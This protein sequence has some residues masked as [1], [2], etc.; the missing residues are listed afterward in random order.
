MKNKLL[1]HAD[2]LSIFPETDDLEEYLASYYK[3]MGFVVSDLEVKQDP[4][5]KSKFVMFT[6]EYIEFNSVIN[7]EKFKKGK[8]PFKGLAPVEDEHRPYSIGYVT[9]DIQEMY[10]HWRVR[11]YQVEDVI[12][13]LHGD[14]EPNP[15]EPVDPTWGY[16]PFPS[17]FAQGV[18]SYVIQYLQRPKEDRFKFVIGENGIY[19]LSGFTFVTDYPHSRGEDWSNFFYSRNNHTPYLNECIMDLA[20]HFVHWI[21]PQKFEM[22]F[23]TEFKPSKNKMCEMYIVHLLTR[24]MNHT[25]EF[26]RSREFNFSEIRLK[27]GSK[28]QN[29]I[30]TE[31]NEKDGLTFAITERDPSEWLEWRKRLVDEDYA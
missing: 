1:L 10:E 27:V 19:G 8:K 25:K 6:A 28:R 20:P 5:L 22:T 12:S 31:R 13:L 7:R 2:H 23:K 29:T 4:G 3:N 11:G 26:F 21:T 16:I 14:V 18:R 17:T 9:E 30:L 24:D 15:D